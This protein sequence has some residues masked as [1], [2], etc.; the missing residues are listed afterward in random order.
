MRRLSD[1]VILAWGAKRVLLCIFAGAVGVLALPPIGF[2]AAMFVSFT[3]LVW[4]MD[5]TAAA[6]NSG[7][8]G[9]LRSAFS[10]GWLFGFGYFVAGLWW[11]GHALL[12]DADEFLWALPLAILGLPAILAIFYGLAAMLA[13][14]FWSEGAGRIA[15]LAAAFGICEWLRSF[16]LTGFPWNMIGY[17][18]TPIPIMMQS[19]HLVGILGITSLAVF[20]FSAPAL[21]WTRQGVRVGMTVAV[22]LLAA[23]IGYG[24]FRLHLAAK[25]ESDE[26]GS[27]TVIRLVQPSIDQSDKMDTD[28]D[29]KAIFEKHLKLSTAQ[30]ANGGRKPDII[31]WPETALPFIL[32]DNKDALTMIAD[33]LDDNQILITGAVRVEEPMPGA[34]ARYYNSI[35][36]IDGRGQILS[37]S[38]KVH[39]VP[40][41]EY[42]PYENL[43]DAFGIR[44]IVEIPGGFSAAASRHLL[45]LPSGLKLYPV[46]CYEAIFPGE[47]GPEIQQ[48]NAIL[49]VTNDAWFGDTPGPYQHFLQAR[50]RA[51]ETGLPL[52]RD[53]NNGISALVDKYGE[54][55]TGLPLN[56]TGYA[57]ATLRGLSAPNSL[58][59]NRGLNFG[60]IEVFLTVGALLGRFGFISRAN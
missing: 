52:I 15:S 39:L 7:A 35:Y 48:A 38:D 17:G 33:A 55:S 46:I 21:L 42:V 41:G 23:H 56:E 51:V 50:L 20:V 37:A 49:N 43:L 31:V 26:S 30:P 58:N 19:A 24:F 4:L 57:D 2:F 14:I 45:T 3:L 29:R 1:R 8:F 60:L 18:M 5:G 32:T 13:R 34:P 27:E 40:F 44:N 22:I 6:P 25:P 47:F 9:N 53:A 11:L 36:V 12:I 59:T 28:A 54:I 16:I 10:T